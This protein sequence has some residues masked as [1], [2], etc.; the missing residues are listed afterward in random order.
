MEDK[1]MVKLYPKIGARCFLINVYAQRE[2]V[3]FESCISECY[4]NIYTRDIRICG[5]MMRLKG[6]L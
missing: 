6:Q 1:K 4:V 5:K 2:I 3:I